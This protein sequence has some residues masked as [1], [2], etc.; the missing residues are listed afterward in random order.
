M[1][2]TSTHTL[3]FATEQKKSKLDDFFAEFERV[4]NCFIDLWWDRKEYLPTKFNSSH[5][6]EVDSWL[7]YQSFR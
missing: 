2:R 7:Y 5:Y 4:V 3:K 1:Q 6:S